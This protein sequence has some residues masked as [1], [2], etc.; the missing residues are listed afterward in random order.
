MLQVHVQ[1]RVTVASQGVDTNNNC[2]KFASEGEC[3]T[4]PELLGNRKNQ[5]KIHHVMIRECCPIIIAL[6]RD[7]D[8]RWLLSHSLVLAKVDAMVVALVLF[9]LI[10][11]GFRTIEGA[12]SHIWP[13]CQGP[14]Y[15]CFLHD[16]GDFSP[17]RS[18]CI[19]G[20][21]VILPLFAGSA[22]GPAANAKGLFL[23]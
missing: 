20:G 2:A 17:L 9:A 16:A 14:Y 1:Q 18:A 23:R 4:N 15:D 21:V 5:W 12:L 3:E 7:S 8:A 6:E 22:D 11:I 13:F 10:C 19:T